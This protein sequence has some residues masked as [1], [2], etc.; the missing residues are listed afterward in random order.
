MQQPKM[1]KFIVIPLAIG[2][3]LLAGFGGGAY[4]LM[5]GS[6]TSKYNQ[7]VNLY[8]A[9]NYQEAAKQFEKLGDYRDSKQRTAEAL[10]RM[11][12]ENG[13]YAFSTGDYEK[14]KEEYIA[15]GDYENSKMLA[16]ECERA[17]HYAKAETLAAS[18]D[19]DKAIEEY[20]KSGYKDFNDKVADLYTAKSDKAIADGNYDQAV[21][22][23]KAAS[24][25]KGSE[26]PVLG[27][28]YKMGEAALA[29]NDLKNSGSYFTSA[30]DY[31][32]APEKA[33]SVYYTLGTE[34]LGNK[35]Y[36]NAAGYFKLAGDYKDTATIAKEAFYITATNKY[37][38][39][40][41][42]AA[43][44]FFELAGDYKDAKSLYNASYYN[45]GTAEL[46]AGK[47]EAAAEHF[48]LCGSYKYAK[49]LVNV[50]AGEE[51]IA[52]QKIGKAMSAYNKV[53]KKASVSGFNIQARKTFVSNWYK[54]D[55]ICRN[56]LVMT[57]W[58]HVEKRTYTQIRGYS[59]T[60]IHP[61]QAI[62][63]KYSVNPNGTFNVTGAVSWARFLNCPASK[64]N[65]KMDLHVSRFQFAGIKSFP[66][67]IKLS[68]GAKLVYKNGR[69][70]VKY[71]KK[72]GG[73]KYTSSITYT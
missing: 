4:Y 11:H 22:F 23:A 53:S 27:C 57:N 38:S 12:F 21:E 56:Y 62:S 9:G 13:K 68:G 47:F 7:A 41:Y 64:A 44:E 54:M 51:A 35:D 40:D 49:D 8:T 25:S 34:A 55:N 60:T 69:F 1:W 18:G 6:K 37:N 26:E 42:A 43:G 73:A 70:T 15:A 45:L 5:N 17:A 36:E 67:K 61:D 39:K 19:P 24:D 31:K 3:V 65:L 28:Y 10:T 32:D 33:K 48:K 16:E 63:I 29:K 2:I 58:I 52:S 72:S 50:C 20:R 30:K 14:A 71:N 46:K 59:F 66:S